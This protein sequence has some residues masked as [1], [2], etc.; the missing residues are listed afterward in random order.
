MKN[1]KSNI[2]IFVAIAIDESV[3]VTSPTSKEILYINTDFGFQI[4]LPNR[5]ENY[6]VVERNDL[7]DNGNSAY[8]RSTF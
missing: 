2:A 3:L 7:D 8:I 5:R 6:Y 1:K 4:T